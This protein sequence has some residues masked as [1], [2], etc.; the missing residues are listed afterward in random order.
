MVFLEKLC[1]NF[2]TRSRYFAKI[3]FSSIRQNFFFAFGL[4]TT[5]TGFTT[6]SGYTYLL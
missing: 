2:F 6:V 1:E 3:S 5:V 4:P